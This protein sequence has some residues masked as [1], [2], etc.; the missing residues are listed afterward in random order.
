VYW[1]LSI[2]G[3]PNDAPVL[4]RLGCYRPELEARSVV[5]VGEL[6]VWTKIRQ[7]AN[8]IGGTGAKEEKNRWRKLFVAALAA[9]FRGWQNSGYRIVP[10]AVTP[11]N[12]VVPEQDFRESTKILSLTGWTPYENSLSLIRPMLRNFYKRTLAYY[13]YC[14]DCL[15]TSWILD[16]CIEGLEE[17]KASDFFLQL[18]KDLSRESVTDFDDASFGDLLSTYRKSRQKTYYTPLPVHNAVERFHEWSLLNPSATPT[19]R[20]QMITELHDLYRLYRFQETARYHLY[21]HTYFLRSSAQVQ[22]AFDRLL[23]RMARDLDSSAVQTTELSELQASLTNDTDRDIFSRMIFPKHPTPH[24]IEVLKVGTGDHQEVIVQSKIQ[25]QRNET[26]VF[27]EPVEPREIGQLYRLFF[28]ESYPISVSEQDRY[29]IAIDG[30]ERIIGGISYKHLE[31]DVSRLDGIVVT[32][33]LKERGIG[34]AMLQDFVSRMNSQG[35]RIVKTFFYRPQFFIKHG[36]QV[37]E[38]WGA[39]VKF[40]SQEDSSANNEFVQDKA[41]HK[42]S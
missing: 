42:P 23:Q 20:E 7:F 33:S 18:E 41:T 37:D 35:I 32:T 10:G 17:E 9:F 19:A 1:L 36:F 3:N 6:T 13:P 38:R 29:F 25:D 30:H 27:R 39:L 4:P 5:Y 12:V 28:E 31:N 8:E 21:R 16:A 15:D 22:R 24:R 11:N 34:S 26:Y 14:R 40:I 2:A